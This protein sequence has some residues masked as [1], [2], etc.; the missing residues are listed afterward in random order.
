MQTI[1][2]NHHVTIYQSRTQALHVTD[3]KHALYRKLKPELL[4]IRTS[5]YS[6]R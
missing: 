2:T 6:T 5:S 3:L 4:D 1:F